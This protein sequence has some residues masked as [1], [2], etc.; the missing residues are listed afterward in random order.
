M[1]KSSIK[2]INQRIR[3]LEAGIND[4]AMLENFIKG[5]NRHSETAIKH[6]FKGKYASWEQYVYDRDRD[7]SNQRN[8]YKHN[9]YAG[10]IVAYG[11]SVLVRRN[12]VARRAE[13]MRHNKGGG[14]MPQ[15]DSKLS[16]LTY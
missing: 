4:F 3:N 11:I 12:I 7:L 14:F 13:M 8:V 9:V 5:V 1:C 2:R 10:R 6:V 15:A 16:P